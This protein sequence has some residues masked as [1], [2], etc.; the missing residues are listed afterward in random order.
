MLS[1]SYGNLIWADLW[2]NLG[3]FWMVF[4]LMVAMMPEKFGEDVVDMSM[5]MIGV[6]VFIVACFVLL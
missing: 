5:W 3:I 1:D 2:M 4:W 6:S